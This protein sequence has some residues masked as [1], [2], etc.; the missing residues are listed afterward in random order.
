MWQMS[1]A[2]R[3]AQNRSH[4][5]LARMDVLHGGRPVRSLVVDEG[6]VSA[7]AMRAVMRNMSASM[8]DPTGQLR[9]SDVGDLLS[10]YD[11]ELRP[12]R[13]IQ[14]G[15]F[16][17]WVPFG[18][19]QITGQEVNDDGTVSVTCQDR[20]IMYQGGMAGS[21]AISAGTPVEVAIRQLLLT[22]NSG[23]QMQTWKT[24]YTCGPLLYSPDIDVWRE[25]QSLAQSVG[26]WLYHD[27]Q[28]VCTFA[29][30]VPTRRTPVRRY[31]SGD[32]VL[33]SVSRSVDADTVRNLVI[34]RSSKTATGGIIEGRAGDTN[35][36][37]PTY[38]RG[39]YGERPYVLTNQHVGSVQQAQ[40][41]AAV[42]LT[43]QLG[44]QETVAFTAVPDLGLDPLDVVTLDYA[45]SGLSDR[46]MTTTTVSTPLGVED[47]MS[48]G[49]QRSLLTQDGRVLD[50][51]L[52]VTTS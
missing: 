38:I 28:G 34:V 40:Q 16:V 23:L 29:S 52:L 19:F 39:R 37:S 7:E 15:S 33:L 6:T 36:L 9:A 11:C 4:I 17:E 49:T 46:A 8:S 30:M 2:A 18:V 13:G 32:G 20:A 21:L 10:P 47:S 51:P 1:S 27:R 5:A 50:V 25:A 42:E 44:R 26:G 12:Y 35:P 24:G 14:L 41:A 22:R 45:R 31:Y 48:V 3:Y 43:R